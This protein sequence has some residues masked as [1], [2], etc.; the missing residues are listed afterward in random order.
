MCSYCHHKRKTDQFFWI[1]SQY[2]YRD[3]EFISCL[4]CCYWK[5]KI[6]STYK[7]VP[8]QNVCLWPALIY[9]DFCHFQCN[10]FSQNFRSL[11]I[12]GFNIIGSYSNVFCSYI[13]LPQ[14]NSLSVEHKCHKQTLTLFPYY[15]CFLNI[16]IMIW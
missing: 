5:S 4:K 11:F 8:P 15:V 9:L 2:M 10:C 3:A 13:S 7:R 14:C 12:I 1:L 6:K 16:K